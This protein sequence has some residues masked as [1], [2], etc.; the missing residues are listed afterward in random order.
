MAIYTCK[1][2]CR[3]F[4]VYVRCWSKL[5]GINIC[6]DPRNSSSFSANY[7]LFITIILYQIISSWVPQWLCVSFM[8]FANSECAISTEKFLLFKGGKMSGVCINWCT[9]PS[10]SLNSFMKSIGFPNTL[11]SCHLHSNHISLVNIG[12]LPNYLGLL[13]FREIS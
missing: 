3:K 11:L 7:R 6:M 10:N 9:Q 2:G 1:G 13:W 8:W 12:A 5:S 4:L